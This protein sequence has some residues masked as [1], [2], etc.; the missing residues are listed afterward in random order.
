[1]VGLWRGPAVPG[2]RQ[3]EPAAGDGDGGVDG[4]G[5]A[6]GGTGGAGGGQE[7]EEDQQEGAAAR[8]GGVRN[9]VG[10]GP[11]GVQGE[12]SSAMEFYCNMCWCDVI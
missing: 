5:A 2:R 12:F 8:R 1:M 9:H 6:G 7:E 11:A 4:G 10:A 3:P